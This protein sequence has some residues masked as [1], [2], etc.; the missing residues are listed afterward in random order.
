MR[1]NKLICKQSK[2]LSLLNSLA[3]IFGL[4]ILGRI[5]YIVPAYS[6]NSYVMIHTITENDAMCTYEKLTGFIK[7]DELQDY[8]KI[9]KDSGRIYLVPLYSAPNI[10]SYCYNKACM[11]TKQLPVEKN[12]NPI[13][14]YIYESSF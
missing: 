14:I 2:L 4:I 3:I 10:L 6:S 9:E 1:S 5:L 12:S 7:D 11:V 13:T 8:I